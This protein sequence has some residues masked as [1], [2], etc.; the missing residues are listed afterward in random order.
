ML[1]QNVA[2]SHYIEIYVILGDLHKRG[3]ISFIQVLNLESLKSAERICIVPALNKVPSAPASCSGWSFV[4]L[5]VRHAR[6]GLG[7]PARPGDGP[8][9]PVL[10]NRLQPVP[11]Q[12]RL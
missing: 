12:P 3:Q 6:A 9:P 8:G 2:I 10:L 11:G 5:H 7:G 4:S 1:G